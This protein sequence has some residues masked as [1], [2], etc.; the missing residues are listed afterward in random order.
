MQRMRCRNWQRKSSSF[1]VEL[2]MARTG[3]KI[4]DGNLP[5]MVLKKARYKPGVMREILKGPTFAAR[6]SGC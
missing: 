2:R 5:A 3:L 6:D 4:R 1:G